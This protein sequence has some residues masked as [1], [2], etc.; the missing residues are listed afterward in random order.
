MTKVTQIQ[1]LLTRVQDKA[2]QLRRQQEDLAAMLKELELV[3]AEC[4]QHLQHTKL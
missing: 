2:A 1:F 3:E 4:H